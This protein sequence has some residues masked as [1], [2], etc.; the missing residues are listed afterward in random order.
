MKNLL[1]RDEIAAAFPG[2]RARGVFDALQRA[3][4]EVANLGDYA[5]D[6]AAAGGGVLVGGLYRTGSALMIRV[7]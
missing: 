6:A 4:P 5:D 1:T 7:T 2:D 3:I